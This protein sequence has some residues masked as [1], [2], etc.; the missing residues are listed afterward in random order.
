MLIINWI[1]KRVV[2]GFGSADILIVVGMGSAVGDSMFY[3]S[4]PLIVA[5]LVITLIG[6]LQKL[7]VYLSIKFEAV[8]KKSH[9]KVMK[10]VE[11]G[12][13][14]YDNFSDDQIDKYEVYML[15]RE[16]GIKYLSEVEHAY[17]EQSGKLSIYKY[18]NPIQE[19]SILPEDLPN[20]E[21]FPHSL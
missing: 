5:L 13:L 15:L 17:Y 19:H 1:G 6:A 12:K 10:L 21:K 16:S 9:P 18:E 11:S 3:P 8:R 7:H 14:L 20:Y 2:G 4:I